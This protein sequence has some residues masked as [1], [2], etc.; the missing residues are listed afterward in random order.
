[1]PGI[2]KVHQI[3][4]GY[5]RPA[6][7]ALT[8]SLREILTANPNINTPRSCLTSS[9]SVTRFGL[10]LVPRLRGSDSEGCCSGTKCNVLLGHT[11]LCAHHEHKLSIRTA[12]HRRD[13]A[14]KTVLGM[15][16]ELV[17]QRGCD[18]AATLRTQKTR[19]KPEDAP[20]PQARCHGIPPS[21][22]LLPP[23]S[24]RQAK[25]QLCAAP[26]SE[27][28]LQTHWG[29]RAGPLQPP[30][31][32]TTPPPRPTRGFC[33]GRIRTRLTWGPQPPQ[34]TGMSPAR[35]DQSREPPSRRAPPPAPAPGPPPSPPRGPAPTLPTPGF[36]RRSSVRNT[37]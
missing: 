32:R 8:N 29:A 21:A 18:P 14:R 3:H 34:L 10:C 33:C 4:L 22:W 20:S 15:E 26:K 7:K 36:R 6:L 25:A 30:R 16:T 9:A 24:H 37:T 11:L 27:P 2:I 13:P 5:G 35:N 28:G 19:L 23:S 17:I 1:M 12:T 31:P